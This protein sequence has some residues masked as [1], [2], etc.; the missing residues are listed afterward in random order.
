MNGAPERL[1][2]NSRNA[3]ALFCGGFGGPVERVEEHGEGG[4]GLGAVLSAGVVQY[5][6][7]RRH[8]GLPP[9]TEF[10]W[11]VAHL[12][13]VPT[14]P[15]TTLAQARTVLASRIGPRTARIADD[16]ERERFAP[17]PC[18]PRKRPFIRLVRALLSDLGPVRALLFLCGPRPRRRAGAA[19]PHLTGGRR[20]GG[21][22][23]GGQRNGGSAGAS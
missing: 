22:R 3:Q 5:R 16:L 9:S 12:A 6:R 8:R 7:R 11:R 10:L 1:L 2:N 14:E 15:S 4:M 21:D 13:G 19:T 20:S 17:A 18:A 23:S